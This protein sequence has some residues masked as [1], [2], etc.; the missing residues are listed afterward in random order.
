MIR[1]PAVRPIVDAVRVVRRARD[2]GIAVDE[3]VAQSDAFEG[4]LSD[5]NQSVA[6]FIDENMRSRRALTEAFQAIGRDARQTAESKDQVGLFGD[7]APDYEEI[8][9]A[10]LNR[11]APTEEVS[12]A[13]PQEERR[14]GDAAVPAGDS[15]GAGPLAGGGE[16]GDPGGAAGAAP[17]GPERAVAPPPLPDTPE[18][19][20]EAGVSPLEHRSQHSR[21]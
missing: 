8:F 9:D 16:A 4:E 11:E 10:R 6:R 13:V 14:E 7:A 17:E 2:E 12:P 20:A 3:A 15:E 5:T 1:E 21:A 19:P 18:T